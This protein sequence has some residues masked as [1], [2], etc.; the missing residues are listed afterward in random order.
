[1]KNG[2]FGLC[3]GWVKNHWE[4]GS[5]HFQVTIEAHQ[6]HT[7]TK[8]QGDHTTWNENAGMSIYNEDDWKHYNISEYNENMHIVEFAQSDGQ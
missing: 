8:D 3:V 2:D 6:V 1:M 7:F 5:S 4:F